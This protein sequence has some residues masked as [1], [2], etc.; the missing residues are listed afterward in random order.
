MDS[1]LGTSLINMYGKCRDIDHAQKLLD[2]MPMPER[3]A[4]FGVRQAKY[5]V[6]INIRATP[7][8]PSSMREAN[9][10]WRENLA[11][12]MTGENEGGL[13]FAIG[14]DPAT[15]F[16][17]GQVE[18]DSERYVVRWL[19]D[20]DSY[21]GTSLINMYGK[22]RDI[23]HAQKLLDEMPMPERN[24]VFGVRQAKHWVVINIRLTVLLNFLLIAFIPQSC[25][26]H[27]TYSKQPIILTNCVRS[28]S[29]N[30]HSGIGF[31][32]QNANSCVR[33]ARIRMELVFNP[34]TI[35][36]LL[37]LKCQSVKTLP[38]VRFFLAFTFPP[39]PVLPPSASSRAAHP[40]DQSTETARVD[41]ERSSRRRRKRA[42]QNDSVAVS[43]EKLADSVQGAVGTMTAGD[44]DDIYVAL[45]RMTDLSS[46]DLLSAMDI[47]CHDSVK[48]DIFKRLPNGLKGIWLQ[49]QFDR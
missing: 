28:A 41:A 48:R 16:L 44:V 6:V 30:W 14:H 15:R 43:I 3:N 12:L 34:K 42:G 37:N 9:M 45:T 21:L 17:G 20:M 36:I 26:E 2:E 23:D 7:R 39:H 11:Y 22:C 4:V 35:D 19:Q 47:L 32:F 38:R 5:W 46:Q 10:P 18:L 29:R 27:P 1:Y 40:G 49:M 25:F 24:A 31:G 33:Y 8:G 13:F